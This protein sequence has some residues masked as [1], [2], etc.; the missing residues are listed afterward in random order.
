VVAFLSRTYA[1]AKAKLAPVL[2]EFTRAYLGAGVPTAG[3]ACGDCGHSLALEVVRRV[4]ALC[5][6]DPFLFRTPLDCLAEWERRIGQFGGVNGQA[7]TALMWREA[8]RVSAEAGSMNSAVRDKVAFENWPD[9]AK[10]I[11]EVIGDNTKVFRTA[12]EIADALGCDNDSNLRGY[13]SELKRAK[14]IDKR[15]GRYV[16]LSRQISAQTSP[17]DDRMVSLKAGASISA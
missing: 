16:L 11:L 1:D 17:V 10:N 6:L 8:V 7:I 12:A 13:L 15:D 5:L 3:D 9:S 14:I 2:P 4:S